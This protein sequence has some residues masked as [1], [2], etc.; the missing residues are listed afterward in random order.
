VAEAAY[1]A[2]LSD[3]ALRNDICNFGERTF[4]GCLYLAEILEIAN[5]YIQTI[6]CVVYPGMN[7]G[8]NS[9]VEQLRYA[10]IVVSSHGLGLHEPRFGGCRNACRIFN[11]SFPVY[12]FGRLCFGGF[13]AC[14]QRKQR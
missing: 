5:R 6:K 8:S 14:S 2:E 7:I 9:V 12:A 13:F 11:C 10:T 1:L 3:K 4:Q